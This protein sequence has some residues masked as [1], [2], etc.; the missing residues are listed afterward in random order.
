MTSSNGQINHAFFFFFFSP[1]LILFLQSSQ[2][3]VCEMIAS[4]A[5][6]H[7][8]VLCTNLPV[9]EL[10]AR[11]AAECLRGGA[12]SPAKLWLWVLIADWQR[13]GAQ[14]C[15]VLAKSRFSEFI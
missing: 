10:A 2:L 8:Q 14:G 4:L 12:Q 1:S 7:G 15:S 11:L 9:Q 13:T 5:V 6:S 3:Y